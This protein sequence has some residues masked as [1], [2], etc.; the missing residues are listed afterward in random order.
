MGLTKTKNPWNIF[1]PRAGRSQA[2]FWGGIFVALARW[3]WWF[4][5]FILQRSA[6][7]EK[8]YWLFRQESQKNSERNFAKT[9]KKI[10]KHMTYTWHIFIY[11]LNIMWF[12]PKPPKQNRLFISNSRLHGSK[13]SR[14]STVRTLTG[15]IVILFVV[16]FLGKKFGWIK[17]SNT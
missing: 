4:W 5:N 11:I 10:T 14:R 6:F 1:R 8:V 17:N 13:S 15:G 2:V 7:F 3:F 9:W 16:F 12:P